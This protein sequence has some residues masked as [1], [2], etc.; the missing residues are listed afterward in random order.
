M[1]SILLCL[2]WLMYLLSKTSRMRLL[3]LKH[4]YMSWHQQA[5]QAIFR[6]YTFYTKHV[7]SNCKALSLLFI[8]HN[9]PMIIMTPQHIYL[10]LEVNKSKGALALAILLY[11]SLM[12]LTF[13]IVPL[14]FAESLRREEEKFQCEINNFCQQYLE[15]HCT[16]KELNY[17]CLATGTFRLRA[18]VEKLTSYLKGRKS[19]FLFGF[20]SFQLQLSMVSLY[21]GLLMLI[22]RIMSG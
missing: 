6:H 3:Q 8:C 15:L 9:I 20:Y 22:I 21:V 19:G 13:W 7:Q 14:Y 16:D 18:E 17:E 12:F 5:E 10:C 2:T 11:Y 1:V 4:E